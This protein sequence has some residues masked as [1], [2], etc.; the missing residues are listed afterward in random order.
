M[1]TTMIELGGMSVALADC[2]WVAFAPCGCPDRVVVADVAPTEELAWQELFLPKRARDRAQQD[3]YRL[4]LMTRE[5]WAAEVMPL[6]R[7]GKCPH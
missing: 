7:A 2:D 5:R 4:E 3:G 6:M 1:N